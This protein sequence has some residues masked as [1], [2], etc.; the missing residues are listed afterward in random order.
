MFLLVGEHDE[1]N[2][3]VHV[4]RQL[5]ALTLHQTRLPVPS[6]RAVTLRPEARR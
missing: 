4:Y 1:K 5:Y 6:R 3:A 2:P